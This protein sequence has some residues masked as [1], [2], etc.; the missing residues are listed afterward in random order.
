MGQDE[1]R[2]QEMGRHEEIVGR[3]VEVNQNLNLNEKVRGINKADQNSKVGRVVYIVYFLFAALGI[4]LGVRLLLHMLGANQENG[5]AFFINN[6]SGIFVFPFASLF[7]N[8]SYGSMVL[9]VTTMVAIL[10]YAVLAW[11][12][13]QMIWLVMS[14]SR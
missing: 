8:P 10:I 12:I 13:G 9:E 2:K 14:R 4:L 6:L 11:G 5:F 3:N 1:L 7:P